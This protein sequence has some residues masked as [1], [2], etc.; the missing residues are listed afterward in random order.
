MLSLTANVVLPRHVTDVY[1]CQQ[2]GNLHMCG[3]SMCSFLR[4]V[5]IDNPTSI[6]NIC[7][8]TCAVIPTD[9]HRR[10]FGAHPHDDQQHPSA[11]VPMDA[12]DEGGVDTD[13]DSADRAVWFDDDGGVAH[14]GE[15]DMGSSTDRQDA[16]PSGGVISSREDTGKDHV[17]SS[18]EQDDPRGW[19]PH[20]TKRKTRR[21]SRVSQHPSA[22]NAAIGCKTRQRTF[23]RTLGLVIPNRPHALYMRMVDGLER[24]WRLLRNGIPSHAR[25]ERR[26]S[27]NL[28]NLTVWYVY[29]AQTG[30]ELSLHG[31][32]V[33]LV[34][35]EPELG[36]DFVQ[37]NDRF[38]VR[39]HTNGEKT[40]QFLLQLVTK[41][42][43]EAFVRQFDTL[44]ARE[45]T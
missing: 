13:R 28:H 3:S 22:Q 8:L 26:G 34:H 4:D 31:H 25:T 38:N 12:E 45:A 27:L 21:K 15:R 30:W 41:E 10:T 23:M 18:K 20:R 37:R 19:A 36:T 33:R 1:V 29:C 14:L 2:S 35:R 24:L 6:H 7:M 44:G 17:D 32:A 16:N 43:V 9:F 39:H 42:H 5:H 40:V 11:D